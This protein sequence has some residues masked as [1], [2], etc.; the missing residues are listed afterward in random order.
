MENADFFHNQNIPADGD[1]VKNIAQNV[2]WVFHDNDINAYERQTC[3]TQIPKG[4]GKGAFAGALGIN[5]LPEE[6]SVPDDGAE[7]SDKED[8]RPCDMRFGACKKYDAD[9]ENASGEKIA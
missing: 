5:P 4:D 6:P 9:D 8:R 3:E 2:N 1:D 7:P